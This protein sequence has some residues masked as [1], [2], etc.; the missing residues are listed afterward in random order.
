[1]NVTPATDLAVGGKGVLKSCPPA[2][3]FRPS[4]RMRPKESDTVQDE[5]IL[6]SPATLYEL[7][8]TRRSA[9]PPGWGR[10]RRLS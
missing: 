7:T 10:S 1:L 5:E 3:G 2:S 4:C 8:T 6:L 9:S